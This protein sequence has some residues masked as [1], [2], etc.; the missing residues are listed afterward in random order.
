MNLSKLFP[1]ILAIVCLL[2]LLA[3]GSRHAGRRLVA[4][5]AGMMVIHLSGAAWLGLAFPGTTPSLAGLLTMSLLPFLALD[6]AKLGVAE[7]LT[8][9]P[10]S[11]S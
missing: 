11:A 8:R 6:L 5:L 10:S 3:G 2:S 4:G 1:K 9:P 7:W